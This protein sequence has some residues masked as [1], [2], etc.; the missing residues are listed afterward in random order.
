VT[1][2]T[3]SVVAMATIAAGRTTGLFSDRDGVIAY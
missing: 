2:G 3:D 1:E